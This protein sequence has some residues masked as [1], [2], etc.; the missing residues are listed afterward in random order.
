MSVK[1]SSAEHSSQRLPAGRQG[2]A[3]RRRNYR[4]RA[5]IVA[6]VFIGILF[7]AFAWWCNQNYIRISHVQIYGADDSFSSYAT[8]AMQGKYLGIIP[9]DSTF[10]FPASRIRT[11]ILSAYPDIAAVSIFRNGLTGLAIKID[12][13]VPDARW[14]G[15]TPEISTSTSSA[16]NDCYFFDVKGFVY[17]TTTVVQPMNPFVIYEPVE[18]MFIGATLP[19]ANEFPSAFD[20]ARQLSS[21]GSPVTSIVFRSDEVDDLLTSGTRVTYVIGDEQ[22]AFTALV[23]GHENLNLTDGSVEYIDL[24]FD[25]KMYLKKK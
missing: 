17:A 20:F 6:I 24:R 4:R 11:N 15:S 8:D 13:R 23:S 16:A 3:D 9:R 25:G 7:G 5:I 10:F 22:N 21:L 2:L 1:L 14:C 19:N 12:E 18:K